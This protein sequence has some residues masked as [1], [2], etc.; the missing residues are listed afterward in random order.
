MRIYIGN[1]STDT[2]ETDLRAL[3]E[4]LGSVDAVVLKVH[5]RT[6]ESLRFGLVDMPDQAEAERA[7]RAL[8]GGEF[9]GRPIKV[10]P[11]FVRP[12]PPTLP[13]SN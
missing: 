4:P 13:E 1:L 5:H 2:T 7:I 3:F 6:G 12:E 10:M 8:D 9:L 11:A